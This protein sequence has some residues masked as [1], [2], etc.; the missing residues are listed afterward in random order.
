VRDEIREVPPQH[1]LG[2]VYFGQKAIDDFA[3]E[4]RVGLIASC[5]M[6]DAS[7]STRRKPA[8]GNG[9]LCCWRLLHHRN[10]LFISDLAFYA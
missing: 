9:A 8:A 4:F 10:R 1:Y 7:R 3:L 5:A 6:A 2:K